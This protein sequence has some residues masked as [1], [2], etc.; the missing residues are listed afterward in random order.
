M[1]ILIT[2]QPGV[3]TSVQLLN[4]EV[5]PPT[6]AVHD[7]ATTVLFSPADMPGGVVG[8]AAFARDLAQTVS[9]WEASCRSVAA[10]GR[11]SDPLGSH[12]RQAASEPQKGQQ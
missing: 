1:P 6:L 3:R 12:A 10:L 4:G 11:S 8:A 5:Q 2:V 9:R 7:G